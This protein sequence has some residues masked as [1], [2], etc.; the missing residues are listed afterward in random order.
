HEGDEL[1][2]AHGLAPRATLGA[3][4]DARRP[5]ARSRTRCAPRGTSGPPGTPAVRSGFVRRR[6]TWCS[7]LPGPEGAAGAGD[8]GRESATRGYNA[9]TPSIAGNGVALPSEGGG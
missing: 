1:S 4:P 9:G 2:G 7:R 8:L 6:S 3:G 5:D